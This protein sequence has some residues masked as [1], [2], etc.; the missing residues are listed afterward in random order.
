M[1]CK[2]CADPVIKLSIGCALA[3]V[4]V[5]L[6]CACHALPDLGKAPRGQF[7]RTVTDA[8]GVKC[9]AWIPLVVRSEYGQQYVAIALTASQK[10]VAELGLAVAVPA[11][12]G[13]RATLTISFAACPQASRDGEWGCKRWAE[14]EQHCADDGVYVQDVR[15][16]APASVAELAQVLTHELGHALGVNEGADAYGHSPNARSIMFHAVDASGMVLPEDGAAV[17]KA[18]GR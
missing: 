17:R 12:E 8:K 7:S 11:L 9:S 4:F 3:F 13:E 18:W 14:T 5:Y 10:W 6:F 1:R 16:F 15:I 2:P